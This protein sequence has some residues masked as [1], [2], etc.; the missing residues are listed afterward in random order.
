MLKLSKFD[1]NQN[2]YLYYHMQLVAGTYIGSF[3]ETSQ[4]YLFIHYSVSHQASERN[5]YLAIFDIE[6]LD[7]ISNLNLEGRCSLR[8]VT[9]D[10]G[11]NLYASVH[12]DA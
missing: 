3:Y 6:T 9:F 2:L 12:F 8:H 1:Q 4:H 10:V 5:T 7:F 11:R